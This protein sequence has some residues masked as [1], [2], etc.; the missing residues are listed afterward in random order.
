MA[1]TRGVVVAMLGSLLGS[2]CGSDAGDGSGA[3]AGGDGTVRE[4]W[5]EYCVATFDEA[6]EV[7]DPFGDPEFTAQPGEA[8]LMESFDEFFGEDRATLA[9]LTDYGP[10][11]FEITAPLGTQ[12]FPFTTD[13]EFDAN[14]AYYAVFADVTVFADEAMTT[15]LC[16]LE[17]GTVMPTGGGQRGYSLAGEFQLSGPLTYEVYLDAYSEQCGQAESGFVSAPE[18]QLFGFATNVVPIQSIIGPQ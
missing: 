18:V 8:Y 11:E 5:T 14:T 3:V 17:A 7:L 4:P 6:Y 10:Y 9:F 2:A 13:C 16:M 12:D 1:W 15:E